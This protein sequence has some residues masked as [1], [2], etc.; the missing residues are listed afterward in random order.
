MML[1]TPDDGSL[2]AN[3]VKKLNSVET[4]ILCVSCYYIV[5]KLGD[6]CGAAHFMMSAMM[7]G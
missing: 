7:D 6:F 2:F 5:S 4:L 3:V 1:T